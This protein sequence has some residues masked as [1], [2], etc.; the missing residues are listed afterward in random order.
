MI[1]LRTAAELASRRAAAAGPLA[2]LADSLAADLA[3]WLDRDVPLPPEKA[4]ITRSGGRCPADGTLLAFD[5]AEREWHRC[6][7]QA[8]RQDDR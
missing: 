2:P 7:V 3:P 1:I 5:P 6:P 4:R 8:A